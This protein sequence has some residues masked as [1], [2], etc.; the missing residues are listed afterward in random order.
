VLT[1]RYILPPSPEESFSFSG[2]AV[3][4]LL[5][6]NVIN[7][8]SMDRLFVRRLKFY[9][10]VRLL[11]SIT[12]VCSCGQNSEAMMNYVMNNALVIEQESTT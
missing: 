3:P 2:E 7:I 10:L 5:L 1:K 9:L 11:F 4:K 8:F 12:R 6:Q